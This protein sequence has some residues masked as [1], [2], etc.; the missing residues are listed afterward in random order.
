M[1]VSMFI[2]DIG[3]QFLCVCV[4]SL[5]GFGIRVMVALQNEFGSVLSSAI[6]KRA[7]E[8][9]A[10]EGYLN[11]LQIS[12]VNPSSP[13][14]LLFGRFFDHSFNFSAC[15]WLFIISISS[16]FNLQRLK[17]SKIHP[18]FPGYPLY[19]HRVFHNSLLQSFVFIHC[20]L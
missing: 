10:L 2:S 7:L 16:W 1:F 4:L 17:F 11:V 3:R 8:G 12:P 5:S 6:L 14:L 13:G 9:Q 18:F 19:C 15:N 20:P